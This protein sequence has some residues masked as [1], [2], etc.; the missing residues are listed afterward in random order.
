VSG[1][2]RTP[3][4][5][6]AAQLRITLRAVELYVAMGKLKCTC[7][8][9]P[10]VEYWTRK[11]CPACSHWYDLHDQLADELGAS[12]EPWEWP[13]VARQGP[14]RAGSPA[15]DA[16]IAV[17]MAAFKAAAKARR[18]TSSP[19]EEGS[20]NVNVNADQEPRN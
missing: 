16:G 8:P 2:R 11:E 1:T 20:R 4:D 17:R 5:R 3:L 12:V 9:P 10:P 14:K 6:P 15:M 18:T 13:I 19:R 7:L